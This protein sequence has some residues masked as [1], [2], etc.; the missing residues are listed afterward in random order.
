MAVLTV[1]DLNLAGIAPAYVAAAAGGDTFK[2]RGGRAA[3]IHVK[4]GGAG[5]ITATVN[6][7]TSVA[8]ASAA[9]FDPDV[10]VSVPAGG[11]RVITLSPI[12]RFTDVNGDVAVA[13][14]GVTTVT[15]GVFRLL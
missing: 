8:P 9:T 15:V 7:P 13:Y 5:A 4:N 12:D 14:S 1:Q 11:E 6:D 10:A 3:I 2:P